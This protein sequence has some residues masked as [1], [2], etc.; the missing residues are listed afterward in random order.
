MGIKQVCLFQDLIN[1]SISLASYLC[2]IYIVVN[3]IFPAFNFIENIFIRPGYQGS[4]LY[5]ISFRIPDRFVC[6]TKHLI[7]RKKNWNSHIISSYVVGII[8]IRLF[9]CLC[10]SQDLAFWGGLVSRV[11]SFKEYF[12]YT[13]CRLIEYW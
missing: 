12:I 11:I 8:F 10:P 3:V 6:K 7:T 2:D 9:I 1:L 5:S 4:F 13:E